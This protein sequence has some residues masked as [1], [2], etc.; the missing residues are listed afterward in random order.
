MT[1]IHHPEQLNVSSPAPTIF[2]G[3]CPLKYQRLLRGWTQQDVADAVY[4]L[5]VAEGSPDRGSGLNAARVSLWECGQTKPSLF[6]QKRLCKLFNMNAVE[7]G[8]L[9]VESQPERMAVQ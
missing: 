4:D 7:L 8:F 3:H 5:C 2:P 6:Y 9:H 1:L